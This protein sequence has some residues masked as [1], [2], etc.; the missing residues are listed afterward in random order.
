MMASSEHADMFREPTDNDIAA[1]SELVA[2]LR[3]SGFSL[4]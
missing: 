3:E 4:R 2:V 1:R